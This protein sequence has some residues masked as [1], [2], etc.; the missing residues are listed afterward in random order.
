MATKAASLTK[1]KKFAKAKPSTAKRARSAG[2]QVSLREPGGT[3]LTAEVEDRVLYPHAVAW[4]RLLSSDRGRQIDQDK[5]AAAWRS[6][7]HEAILEL[8]ESGGV[9]RAQ[10][11][12]FIKAA[13]KSGVVQVETVWRLETEGWAARVFPWEALLALATKDERKRIGQIDFVVVRRLTGRAQREAAKGDPA[14]AVSEGA[15]MQGFDY[16]TERAAIEAALQSPLQTLRASSLA[17]LTEDVKAKQPKIVHLV[18]NSAEKGVAISA[19]DLERVDESRT[20]KLA[21]AVASHGPEIVVF[22]SCYTG[23]RVAPRAVFH[24]AKIA[25]GFHG[26]VADASIPVF[27]GAFYRAWKQEPDAL[28]A[29][30]SGLAANKSQ[31]DPGALGTVTLWSADDLTGQGVVEKPRTEILT[32]FKGTGDGGAVQPTDIRAALP[33]ICDLEEALNYSVLHNS[34]G[35]LFK[36]FT[37]TKIKEGAMDE[38]EVTIRLDTGLDR[39]A[40]C[41]FFVSLPVNAD[42]QQDLAL[43]VTLPLGSQLLRQRGESMLGTVEITVNCGTVRV[44]HRLKSI[45][46]LPCD[47]WRDDV[48][49]RHFL[50]SFVF[51]RD[52]AVREILGASQPF[53]RALC[54]QPQAGFDG[55]QCGFDPDPDEA[56][57]WQ[58]RAIWAALQHSIRLDYVNPPPA[59]TNASQRLR[60]PEEILR[61]R[62]ATCIE[63]ALLLASCWEHVGIFPVIFL[64]SGHAFAGYWMSETA[65]SGFIEGLTKPP[66][67]AGGEGGAPGAEALGG[68]REQKAA[69]PWMFAEAHHLAAI[70]REVRKGRLTPVEAT[71]IPLQRSFTDA[72]TESKRL[73]EDLRGTQEFDGMIDVQSAR[74][75]G[76][77]PLAIIA[78]GVVA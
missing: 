18:L 7:A 50:P 10:A 30:R 61:A 15:E 2:Y 57:A 56:V 69:E 28:A 33:V 38:V 72:V 37:I 55:Y 51:P 19:D 29:L 44:Y 4:N 59:Y 52:P 60:T 3:T 71:F 74:E 78:Q 1:P 5:E 17:E 70:R 22:S 11:S 73:L 21:E 75:R 34:R 42:R 66:D 20:G 13:A 67:H 23:R 35:G 43:S 25:M 47:E 63:L 58:T 41:H 62:R 14:F 9:T 49:G 68:R 16:G 32:E 12:S 24:G 54:D 45:K 53:L 8:A 36:V 6:N 39:P 31:S 27:F 76:V 40:E 48:T 26:E 64:T 77:T 46:L 65:R